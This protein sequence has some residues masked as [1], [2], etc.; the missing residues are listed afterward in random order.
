MKKVSIVLSLAAVMFLS[1]CMGQ[2]GVSKKLTGFNLK[3]VDNRYGRAGTY[4]LLSP[5]Y[6]ITAAA[7]LIVFNSIEF[8]TGKNPITGKSPALVDTP[9]DTWMKVN[10][11]LPKGATDVPLSFNGKTIEKTRVK[12][13][14][15]ENIV[16]QMQFEDGTISQLDG[17]I[18]DG[19]LA[20]SYQNELVA[21]LGTES[22][23][24]SYIR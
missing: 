16:L 8:W 4:L 10:D 14:D 17:K 3:A 24:E 1:A 7:D 23:L 21:I 20:F 12:N 19:A 15:K 9:V 13:I 6:A 22:Q 5:V 2:M 11:Q 18:Q